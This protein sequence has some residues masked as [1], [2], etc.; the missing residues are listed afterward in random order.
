MK[1][2]SLQDKLD[3]AIRH[4]RQNELEPA[5]RLYRLI[6]K[7]DES[8]PGALQLLSALLLQ[9]RR[10][11]E[12]VRLLARPV[13]RAPGQAILAVNLGEAYRRLGNFESAA[14]SFRRAIAAKPDLAEAHYNLALTLQAMGQLDE[15]VDRFRRAL[16]I[17]PDLP[18]I[19]FV[20]LGSAL[21][22]LDRLDES[23]S[24]FQRAVELAPTLAE[25]HAGSGAILL[26]LGRVDDALASFRRALQLNPD[27]HVRHGNIVYILGLQPDSSAQAILAEAVRW[28]ERHTAAFVRLRRPHENDRDPERRLRVGYLSP[29]FRHHSHVLFFLPLF[30][31]HDKANVEVFAYSLLETPDEFTDRIRAQVDVFRDV[32]KLNDVELVDA[33]RLDRIDVLV[34]ATMHLLGNRLRALAAQPAPVQLFWLA[35]PGTTG[36]D[37]MY[38]VTDAFLDP[39]EAE[40][41]A[42]YSEQSLR[43]PETFWCYD[44]LVQEPEVGPLPALKR[45]AIT[46]GCLSNPNRRNAEVLSLWSRVLKAVD[47]SRMILFAHP[48]ASRGIVREAVAREGVDPAR[49][50]FVEFQKNRSDYFRL[51]QGIDIGLDTVPHN[52]GTTTL[53][54]YWMGVPVVTL[55][56]RTVVGRAGLCFASNLGLPELAAD[57]PGRFV[58]VAV[59]MSMNVDRLSA[60]RAELRSRMERSPMMDAPRFARNFESALRSAWRDWCGARQV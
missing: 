59:E 4:H 37:G 55:V 20:E 38:R 15:A 60:L 2:G 27:D 17:K 33:I 31:H 23:L 46:F 35:Y 54:S 3:A 52:G 13:A 39:P 49:V 51:Y 29:D 34:D 44:P 11:D 5:E 40:V 58:Q 41:D 12:T 6:L 8:H 28:R 24:A 7:K 48:G 42:C 16:A 26:T 25:A 56:G 22:Q 45:G 18:P 57:S 9:Q 43:L 21:G 1:P 30:G 19:A 47:G 36:L 50:E 10:S 32:S 14:V 53:D